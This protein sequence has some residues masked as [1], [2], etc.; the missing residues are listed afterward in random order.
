MYQT[1]TDREREPDRESKRHGDRG[2]DRE[3]QNKTDKPRYRETEKKEKKR[4]KRHRED[5]QRESLAI[6]SLAQRTNNPNRRLHREAE[7]HHDHCQMTEI[8]S[9]NKDCEA[10]QIFRLFHRITTKNKSRF[11]ST[12]YVPHDY[13]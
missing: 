1:Q 6:Y 10:L 12:V 2:R 8:T 7:Q 3:Q 4:K 13:S 11:R 5:T 9:P